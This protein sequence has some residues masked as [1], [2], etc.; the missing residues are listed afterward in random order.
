MSGGAAS[1]LGG[2]RIVTT[3]D[4]PG[5]LDELLAA[6][7]ADVVHVPLIEI[8]EPS[9]GGAGLAAAL[10]TLADADWL[11]VTSRHGA[12][13]AGDAAARCPHLRLAAV[14]TRTAAELSRRAGRAVDVVPTRQTAEGLLAVMPD[15]GRQA[16]VVVAHAD[17]AEPTLVD[18]LLARGYT[19]VPAVAYRTLLRVPTPD[20]RAA[21]L[22]AD[23]VAFASGSAAEAWAEAIGA[24]TPLRVVA[25]GPTTAAAAARHGLRVT[26][27]A[28]EHSVPGL[29]AA[30]E[31]AMSE[32]ER[33]S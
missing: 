28:A 4:E 33:S 2:C 21:A 32:P 29:V 20:Q 6:R 7:G 13:R 18:G 17:R 12:A 24:D 23:A 22:A 16:R 15:A 27:V 30:I 5:E 11:I 26:H 3:R 8:A 10:A 1:P 14:G 31:A 9:D 25:I 19:V